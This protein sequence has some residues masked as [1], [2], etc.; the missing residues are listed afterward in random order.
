[1]PSEKFIV[2]GLSLLVSRKILALPFLT[3]SEEGIHHG[4]TEDTEI[5][6]EKS[7]KISRGG[8]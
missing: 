5:L 3:F 7:G 1:M 8:I 6:A 2:H 4:D